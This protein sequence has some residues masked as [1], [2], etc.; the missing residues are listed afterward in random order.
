M[1][2]SQLTRNELLLI[3]YCLRAGGLCLNKGLSL[4]PCENVFLFTKG[5]FL[6]S[7]E[8]YSWQLCLLSSNHFYLVDFIC[9][10]FL[11]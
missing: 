9:I 1:L 6:V 4:L 11:L 2:N 10:N 7:I 8:T 3:V 5:L